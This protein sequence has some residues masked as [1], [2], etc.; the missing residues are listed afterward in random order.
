LRKDYLYDP[1]TSQS[2][3]L[4]KLLCLS[5][6][7]LLCSLA[8]AQEAERT[9]LKK[10]FKLNL[11]Y[12]R[13]TVQSFSISNFQPAFS[14][15]SKRS[16]HEL[17]LTDVSYTRS[18]VI[19]EYEPANN[20]E[21]GIFYVYK[22]QILPASWRLNVQPGVSFSFDYR[23]RHLVP[24]RPDV[25]KEMYQD[26]FTYGAYGVLSFVYRINNKLMLDY[27]LPFQ[28]WKAQFWLQKDIGPVTHEVQ[29]L[30]AWLRPE[31]Y[32]NFRLGIR[33]LIA[34]ADPAK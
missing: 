28:F 20:F 7:S 19:D 30:G 18:W 23:C 9:P 16:T 10:F 13:P 15:A 11:S 32:F 26:A 33:Y 2:N 34:K 27:D 22:I 6:F 17:G 25:H 21:M 4:M 29:R 31:G 14:L 1:T 8:V 24:V 12:R 5:I 3:P